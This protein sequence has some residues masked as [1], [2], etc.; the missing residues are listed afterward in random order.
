MPPFAP[1]Y[2]LPMHADA[3]Q[4]DAFPVSERV[5][6]HLLSLPSSPH[7][8]RMQ[9]EEIVTVIQQVVPTCQLKERDPCPG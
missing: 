9:I 7:L 1:L 5:D 6:Q 4:P 2:R 8:T 3:Y